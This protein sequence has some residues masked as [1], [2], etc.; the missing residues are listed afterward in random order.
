MTFQPESAAPR[1]GGRPKWWLWLL[2]ALLVLG[3][4]G[5]AAAI[6]L[7]QNQAP[8][9][10]QQTSEPETPEPSEQPVA[11]PPAPLVIPGCAEANPRAYQVSEEALADDENLSA[12][13]IGLERFSSDF[14]PAAQAAMAGST[15]MRGCLYPFDY[16]FGIWQYTAEIDEAVREPLLAALVADADFVESQVGPARVFSWRDVPAQ[17]V[18]WDEIYT[19]HIFAGDA[20]VAV[21]GPYPPA[22]FTASIVDGLVAANPHLLE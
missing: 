11:T 2:I 18:H 5:G 3:L 15:Q 19:T 8:E 6:L 13:E 20:W 1:Q 7:N 17:P 22:E 14:G 21:Y 4:G 16:E 9:A 10:P 12:S